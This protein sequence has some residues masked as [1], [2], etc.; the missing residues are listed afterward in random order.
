MQELLYAE[1][2]VA[3]LAD[4]Q[5]LGSCGETRGGSTPLVRTTRLRSLREP[6]PMAIVGPRSLNGFAPKAS[7]QR[8]LAT[9]RAASPTRDSCIVLNGFCYGEPRACSRQ[10]GPTWQEPRAGSRHPGRGYKPLLREEEATE[11][12]DKNVAPTFGRSTVL[13][14]FLGI[15]LRRIFG[16]LLLAVNG[17]SVAQSGRASPCQG[18]C[19]GFESLRS[20]HF[21]APMAT[22]GSCCRPLPRGVPQFPRFSLSNSGRRW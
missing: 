19:R 16:I 9:F 8:R 14:D 12:R 17:A 13:L 7:I 18:E 11:H 1:A 4:A 22:L 2:D 10:G 21:S 20:L 5:D 6:I 15:A 3:E